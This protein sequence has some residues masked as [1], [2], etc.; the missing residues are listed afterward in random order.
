MV[1]VWDQRKRKEFTGK[2]TVNVISCFP[3]LFTH[4]F[5]VFVGLAFALMVSTRSSLPLVVQIQLREPAGSQYLFAGIV[6]SSKAGGSIC[7]FEALYVPR[8]PV[9]AQFNSLFW[10]KPET[11]VMTDE[12]CFR[13]H[14]QPTDRF[15]R[16]KSVQIFKRWQ[17]QRKIC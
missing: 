7:L 3:L 2:V 11:P 14:C 17:L 16:R 8:I 12:G 9:I 1:H 5:A 15:T 4:H 10:A 13:F 6:F